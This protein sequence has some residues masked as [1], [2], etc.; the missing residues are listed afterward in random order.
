MSPFTEIEVSM[1]Y[2]YFL[3]NFYYLAQDAPMTMAEV[4]AAIE[5]DMRGNNAISEFLLPGHAADPVELNKTIIAA[6]DLPDP[7]GPK[8]IAGT[9][10]VQRL[11]RKVPKQARQAYDRATT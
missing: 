9:V 7:S 10:S 4:S 5:K 2:V 8:S 1:Y 3:L 11:L 6:L